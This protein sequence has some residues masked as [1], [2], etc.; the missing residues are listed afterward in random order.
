MIMEECWKSIDTE[1]RY[2]VSNLGNIRSF[3]DFHGKL[4]SFP[5][6]IHV[7]KGN[8]GYLMAVLYINGGHKNFLVH[9]LVAQAFIPNPNNYKCVNHKDENKCNNIV[10]NLE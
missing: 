3:V 7:H 5:H 9:R 6:K 10:D 1:G 8:S 2:E 4:V